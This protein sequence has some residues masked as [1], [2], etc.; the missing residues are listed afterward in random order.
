MAF[1]QALLL[2]AISPPLS[3]NA[4]NRTRPSWNSLLVFQKG[5]VIAALIQQ[6]VGNFFPG[7]RRKQQSDVRSVLGLNRADIG[8]SVL[9]YRLI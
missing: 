6:K 9:R 8:V 7:T 2:G 5:Q 1:R 4:T 3:F